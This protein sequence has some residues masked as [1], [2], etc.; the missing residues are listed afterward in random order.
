MP[1]L[2]QDLHFH[3]LEAIF[4]GY[5]A[6]SPLAHAL[7]RAAEARHVRTVDIGKPVLDLGCGFGQF[8]SIAL[9]N[10]VDVGIDISDNEISRAKSG[11][12]YER[13]QRADGGD[14]PFAD[15]Q[16]RSVISISVLE[17]IPEPDKVLE[18]VSRVLRPGGQ[19]IGT[20]VLADLHEH[21]F[22]PKLLRSVGLGFLA[23]LYVRCQDRCFR[24]RTLL[25]K[26]DWEDML[27]RHG[28]EIELS[29]RVV[30]PRVTASWDMLLPLALPYRL[31]GR[32]GS[33]LVWHPHW[34]RGLVKKRFQPMI[35]QEE[36][37]GSVLFFVARKPE[38][39]P[40]ALRPEKPGKAEHDL[41]AV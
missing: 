7:F 40:A 23:R 34:L 10:S 39:T 15:E 14:L 18:E 9:Q 21:L 36:S 3:S 4:D 20:V 2:E 28:L 16:F 32:F 33:A 25:P 38:R 31:L 26:E 37:A 30:S 5:L 12:G 13:L 29:Q 6:K 35:D 1:T 22:Y 27:V 8:A 24:H 17:H 11:K 19:F 41:V